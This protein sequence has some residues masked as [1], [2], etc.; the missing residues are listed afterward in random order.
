MY[1]NI[2]MTCLM[3]GFWGDMQLLSSRSKTTHL[4]QLLYVYYTGCLK[5]MSW[6]WVADRRAVI[7]WEKNI[8][9]IIFSFKKCMGK[10]LAPSAYSSFKFKIIDIQIHVIKITNKKTQIQ[11]LCSCT[12]K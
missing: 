11:Q 7:E 9:E 2:Y 6:R 12:I 4:V 5:M 1:N 10:L 8:K 3:N